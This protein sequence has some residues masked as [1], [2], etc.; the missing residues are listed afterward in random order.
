[1]R[2]VLGAAEDGGAACLP[3]RRGADLRMPGRGVSGRIRIA[4]PWPVQ[5][6]MRSGS[7]HHPAVGPVQAKSRPARDRTRGHK[8]TR[9]VYVGVLA[10]IGV[11]GALGGVPIGSAFA[12]API[13]PLVRRSRPGLL[14][15]ERGMGYRDRAHAVG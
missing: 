11:L 12:T 15:E 8:Q 5:Y 1:V 7:F 3:A 10:V 2:R 6:P 14:I 13:M 4:L 9:G